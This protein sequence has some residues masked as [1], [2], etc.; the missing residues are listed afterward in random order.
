MRVRAVKN[1]LRLLSIYGPEGRLALPQ[2]SLFHDWRALTMLTLESHSGWL[3]G[4]DTIYWFNHTRLSLLR[5]PG[6]IMQRMLKILREVDR[7]QRD[8]HSLSDN[9]DEQSFRNMHLRQLRRVMRQCQ[10]L[11]AMRPK[12]LEADASRT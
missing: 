4:F 12:N 7:D 9:D 3:L 6:Q 8:D 1:T 10:L 5:D 2:H 11:V